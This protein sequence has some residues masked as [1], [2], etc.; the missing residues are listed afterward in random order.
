MSD[1]N[2]LRPEPST[3]TPTGVAGLDAILRGGFF[4]GGIYMLLARPGSGKTILGNQICFSHVHGGGRAIVVTLLT[5][6][7]AR[8]L[9][10][11]R[12]FSFFDETCVGTSL[13]YVAGYQALE[14]SKLR[15]LLELVRRVVRDHKATLLMIDGLITTGALAESE[16]ETKKFLHEM[17][18][19][20]ELVGCTTLLLTGATRKDDEQYAL[21][22]MVDGLVEL[23]QH[24]VGME[25]AR[26]VEVSKFRGGSVLS[27]KHMFEIS[28]AG[29]TLYPRTEAL[30]GKEPRRPST[31][32][33]VAPFGIG[34]LDTM[35]G[36]GL[37]PSTVT[38]VLGSPGSGK[39]LLGLQLLADGARVGERSLYFGF[40]ETP[41][42]LR[43]K[44]EAIGI[45]LSAYEASGL[46]DLTWCSPRSS[47]ADALA[48]K[49]LAAVK[50]RG[51]RRVFIDGLGGFKDTL[52]Y[53]ARSRRF[54]G[55]LFDEL[56]ALGVVT[57]ASDETR[58]LTDID[59]P[60]RGFTAT[61]DSV[62][63]LRH[64]EV[65]GRLHKLISVLKMREGAG[66][67]SV[68]EFS[69]GASGFV[70]SSLDALPRNA[71]EKGTSRRP[72]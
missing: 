34:D 44:A 26:T 7:H 61:F 52:V 47:I 51:I 58:S 25:S 37:K 11:L 55:A 56:R 64:V 8:L 33:P 30:Y 70:V 17:Q 1:D 32:Q 69:I 20:V 3:R 68:R 9:S 71:R 6:S 60:E 49:L 23:H 5:E 46:I 42:P 24:S 62:I 12:A 31:V 66:D 54:F 29:I 10:Q 43:E 22:T 48:E 41:V 27:G 28:D 13:S 45:S 72:R 14:T 67:A 35:L 40:F 59:V 53:S 19:F 57:L 38:M 65:S 36:G 39:T 50:A 21:R 18:V 4:R 15:G 16:I 2:D 63:G